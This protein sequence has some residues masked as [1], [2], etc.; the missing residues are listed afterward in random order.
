MSAED[1]ATAGVTDDLI[2]FSCGIEHPD[3]LVGD[4]ARALDKV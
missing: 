1:R 4:V 3:D 2:R